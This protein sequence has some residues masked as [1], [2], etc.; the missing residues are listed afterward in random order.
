MVEVAAGE[1]LGATKDEAEESEE[2]TATCLWFH[3]HAQLVC[4]DRHEIKF[5]GEFQKSL[6]LKYDSTFCI[7]FYTPICL[8]FLKVLSVVVQSSCHKAIVNVNFA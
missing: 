8:F 5:D 2:R 7:I 3:A 6:V 4:T 1:E